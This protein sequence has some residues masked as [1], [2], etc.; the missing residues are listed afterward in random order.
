MTGIRMAAVAA[1]LL[2]TAGF[3][4]IA[5]QSGGG[6]VVPGT[7]GIATQSS[8]VSDVTVQHVGKAIRNVTQLRQQYTQRVQASTS[9]QARQELD[10][11]A[12]RDMTKAVTDQGLTLQQYDQVIQLAQADPT[13]RQRLLAVARSND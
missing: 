1:F 13:L 3:P 7:A 4:A 5:Q 2:T 8:S 11:Q 10:T 9:Q 12:Q 6:T